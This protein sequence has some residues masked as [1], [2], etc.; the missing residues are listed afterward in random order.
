MTP[1]EGLGALLSSLLPP[2]QPAPDQARQ[3]C[4]CTQAALFRPGSLRGHKGVAGAPGLEGQGL[5]RGLSEKG[6]L[7]PLALGVCGLEAV[8][9]SRTISSRKSHLGSVGSGCSWLTVMQALR[10]GESPAEPGAWDRPQ[11]RLGRP[12][13]RR[14][15]DETRA[16]PPGTLPASLTSAQEAKSGPLRRGLLWVGS[17]WGS[18]N[19]LRPRTVA[20]VKSN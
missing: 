7:C 18:G 6:P 3:S 15:G 13:G 8:G 17:G 4:L 12:S 10:V 2:R 1:P 5:P 16:G 19:Q 14:V 11:A 20:L 9:G